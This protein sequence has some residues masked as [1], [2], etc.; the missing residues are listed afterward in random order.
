MQNLN[1]MVD[2]FY[3]TILTLNCILGSN[4]I[5]FR[6][7]KSI[8]KQNIMPDPGLFVSLGKYLLLEDG[9]NNCENSSIC[10]WKQS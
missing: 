1:W 6:V 9:S 4:V 7:S 5:T 10:F 8:V 3:F 2:I